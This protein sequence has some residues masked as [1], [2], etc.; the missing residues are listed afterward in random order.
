MATLQIPYTGGSVDPSEFDQAAKDAL[1]ALPDTLT[2][3]DRKMA[4]SGIAA[5]KALLKEGHFGDDHVYAVVSWAPG[6]GGSTQQAATD[7]AMSVGVYHRP[8]PAQPAR[9]AAPAIPQVL[10]SA[11]DTGPKPDEIAREAANTG[12]DV[13]EV[14]KELGA[15]SVTT[16]E[17]KGG[18]TVTTTKDIS[19][20]VST[21]KAGKTPQAKAPKVSKAQA[22]KDAAARD[23]ASKQAQ[24]TV[25]TTGPGFS[26]STTN[27]AGAAQVAPLPSAYNP[28]DVIGAGP[29][30][31]PNRVAAQPAKPRASRSGKRK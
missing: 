30:P 15:K 23:K 20:Q 29:T 2:D 13:E 16:T 24:R 8:R 4:R 10:P 3:E 25:L 28:P 17:T 12:R 7:T 27:E 19:A 1:D 31:Q 22:K 11:Y 5:A 9:T 26:S 18:V 14:A 21:K 6:I